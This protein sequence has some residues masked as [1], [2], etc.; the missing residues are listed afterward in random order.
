[1][2]EKE[3]NNIKSSPLWIAAS[4]AIFIFLI[5]NTAFTLRISE[6]KKDLVIFNSTKTDVNFTKKAVLQTKCP[7]SAA[8][9]NQ[10]YLKIKY[11][12]S[13]FCPWCRKEEPV[14]QRIIEGYGNLVYIEWF[15]VNSCKED[16]DK[17]KLKGV[18]TFVFSTSDEKNE[19]AHYGFI[20]EEDL[21]KLVCDVTGG[22]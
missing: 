19:Y 20:Y 3:D 16:T 4:S 14:L 13:G 22:C 6:V 12:Y 17:Y 2:A 18:P 15:D 11:F 21:K 7:D 8:G 10:S 1:M 9:N 5:L